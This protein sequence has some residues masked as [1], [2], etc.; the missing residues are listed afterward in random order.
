[1]DTY[2]PTKSNV[3]IKNTQRKPQEIAII[4]SGI[5]G[6]SAAW[7]LSKNNNVHVYEKNSYLGGHSNTVNINYPNPQNKIFPINVDTG[8]IV[9]NDKNYPN[10]TRFFQK[11]KIKTINSDMSFSFSIDKG[12]YEYSGS[13]LNGI[14]GQRKNLFKTSQWKLILDIIKFSKIAKDNIYKNNLNNESLKEWLYKNN[15]SSSF[16]YNYIVPMSASIWSCSTQNIF[17]FPANAFLYFFYHHGLLNFR[18]RPKW[19]TVKNGSIEYI[20]ALINNSKFSYQLNSKIKSI[21]HKNNKIYIEEEDKRKEYD[22]IIMACHPH[23]VLKKYKNINNKSKEILKLFK[24]STN[25]VILHRSDQYMP[26][27]KK[28]WSSWN[29]FTNKDIS[30]QNNVQ[31]TYW[32]NKLQKIDYNYPLFIT[33]NI[34]NINDIDENLIFK[35]LKYKH[36]IFN[37]NSLIA[38]EQLKSI[39][40]INN[41]WYSG[42]WTGYG[43]HEDGIKSGIFTAEKLGATCPWKLDMSNKIINDHIV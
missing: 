8:F 11:L 32:M 29:Y 1:M 43:F 23:Q 33:L 12:K 16:I 38:Q 26:K 13:G 35:T 10:L 30:E 42:A 14:F 40:G 22:K 6:L 20:K 31:M 36:P 7:L 41:I 27:N 4:G 5:S 25:Q 19:K 37:K 39:Q 3:I 9:Y 21:I 2:L 17:K 34:N 15:F 28:L 24:Y 18:N